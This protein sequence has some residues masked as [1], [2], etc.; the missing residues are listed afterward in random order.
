[1]QLKP[2]A[3]FENIDPEVF[4]QEYKLY[5]K[6][7]EVLSFADF[8]NFHLYNGK[9]DYK[10]FPAL[11]LAQGYELTLERGDTLLFMPAGY[12]HHME[13][14]ESGFAMSLRAMQ[15]SLAG[16]IKGVW[17]IIGMRNIDTLMKKTMPK[18]WYK[19]KEKK[20]YENAAKVMAGG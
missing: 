18:W 19:R 8:S 5:R 9:P 17:S 16:K 14:I 15:P 3:T 10:Q 13:Y 7:F 6:P 4:K 11:K 1:M 20:L 12:W 2:V